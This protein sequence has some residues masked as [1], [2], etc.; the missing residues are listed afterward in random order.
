MAAGATVYRVLVELS[1]TD[2][3]VYETLT[4][5]LARHPSESGRYLASRTLAYC[6]SY[7]EGIEFGKGGVSSADDP[8]VLVRDASGAMTR[9]IDVGSPSAERIHRASKLTK[10]VDIYTHADL[11][12]LRRE[13]DAGR[14]YAADTIDVWTL[15]ATLLDEL[16]AVL[17]SGSIG[18]VRTGGA[19]Y[20]SAGERTLEGAVG[21]GKL[22]RTR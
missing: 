10:R 11:V 17:A 16:E 2:R 7:E 20:L 8:P 5:R 6:L 19:L 12:A 3:G 21:H 14:V 1:D 13:A 18:V 9:W 4:L 22:G 15:P